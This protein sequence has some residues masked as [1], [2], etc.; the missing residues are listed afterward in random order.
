MKLPSKEQL[1]EGA[2][3]V[4]LIGGV[5]ATVGGVFVPIL[6]PVGVSLLSASIALSRGEASVTVQNLPANPHPA[7]IDDNQSSSSGNNMGLDIQTHI[8][9][10]RRHH[11]H[12]HSRQLADTVPDEKDS[13]DDKR[14][15]SKSPSIQRR[16]RP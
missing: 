11:R 8:D 1:K 15:S 16:D 9:I 10:S 2:F 14:D 7:P 13:D 4:L 5:G 3:W 6:I 12:R